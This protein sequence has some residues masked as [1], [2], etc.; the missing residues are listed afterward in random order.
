MLVLLL[1]VLWVISRGLE[2]LL[3]RRA[4]RKRNEQLKRELEAKRQTTL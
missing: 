4:F 2:E 3:K 1:F